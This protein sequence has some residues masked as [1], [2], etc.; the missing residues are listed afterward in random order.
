M[1]SWCLNSS[2]QNGFSLKL[3]FLVVIIENVF[4]VSVFLSGLLVY[5]IQKHTLLILMEWPLT[6]RKL[7]QTHTYTHSYKYNI[8]TH[9]PSLCTKALT[10]ELLWFMIMANMVKCVFLSLLIPLSLIPTLW[11]QFPNKLPITLFPKVYFWVSQ[12]ETAKVDP[13]RSSVWLSRSELPRAFL[14]IWWR[15]G[16]ML[17]AQLCPILCNSMDYSPL[18]S[19]VHGI[20]QAR[21]LEWVTISFSRGSSQLRDQTQF[22]IA[23]RFFTIWAFREAPIWWKHT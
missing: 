19:S 10:T 20:L 22:C 13:S 15:R 4:S 8:H 11:N 9:C 17:V 16:R 3:H 1:S 12:S 6:D 14:P 7:K 2:S 18:G 5:A 23:G 21:I